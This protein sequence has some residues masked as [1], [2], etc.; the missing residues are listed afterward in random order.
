MYMMFYDGKNIDLQYNTKQTDNTIQYNAHTR[1]QGSYYEEQHT[2]SLFKMLTEIPLIFLECV[3]ALWQRRSLPF[4]T[5]KY[6]ILN[7]FVQ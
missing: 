2:I 3:S 7:E 1:Q 5:K 6:I 4:I